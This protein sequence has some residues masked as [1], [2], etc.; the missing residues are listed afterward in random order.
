M[1]LESMRR[2]YGDKRRTGEETATAL[3]AVASGPRQH[4]SRCAAGED[5]FACTL[6]VMDAITADAVL[7][8]SL[9][10]LIP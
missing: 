3:A 5:Y 6:D 7:N 9:R 4:W 8:C 10:F 2:R 1:A